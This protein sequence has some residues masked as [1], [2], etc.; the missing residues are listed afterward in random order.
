MNDVVDASVAAKWYFPE[1]GWER[2]AALLAERLEDDRELYAPDLIVVE[3]TSVLRKKIG[4]AQCDR[5][6]AYEILAL[7]DADRPEL[8][9]SVDLSARAL[10][11]GLLLDHPVY[12]C[13][14]IAAAI[15]LNAR[16]VTA[17]AGMARAAGRLLADVELLG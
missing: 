17:D 3:L 4:Q 14:Y 13:I 10:E 16:L 15:E 5:D 1:P 12:D 9:S 6:A 8:V 7:F 11:L 2:A